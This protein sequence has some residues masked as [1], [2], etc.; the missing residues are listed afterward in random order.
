LSNFA[1]SDT[2]ADGTA[3]YLAM[4]VP[5]LCLMR[6]LLSDRGS[7]YVHLDWHIGTHVKIMLDDVFGRDSYLNEITWQ[8]TS[9]HGDTKFFANVVWNEFLPTP[10]CLLVIFDQLYFLRTLN[11][12][13]L[14]IV[15]KI[16]MG[17]AF[18]R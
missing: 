2:W 17:V 13:N 9:A 15:I 1:Y 7:I 14:N 12:L 3:S 8:R 11:T 4:I 5:R 10:K 6:E 16:A 18:A